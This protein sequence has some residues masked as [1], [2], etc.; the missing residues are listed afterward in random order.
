MDLKL[1][2]F[3]ANQVTLGKL[4]IDGEL[5]CRAIELPWVKNTRNISCIPAGE[6]KINP[7]NSN[8]FGLTYEVADVVGRSHILFHK[9]NTVNDTEGCILPCSYFGT[10]NDNIAGLASGKAY[11]KLMNMLDG[12]KHKL[13]IERH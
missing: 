4:Y 9:G 13:T 1:I 7:V 11:N 8:R 3:D 10:L 12:E 5:I 2:T 6:Y